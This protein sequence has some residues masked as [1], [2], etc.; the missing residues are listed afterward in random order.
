MRKA[1][2]TGA[3]CVMILALTA[4]DAFT[5]SSASP[6]A[7]L[8]PSVPAEP[9][10]ATADEVVAALG[11]AGVDCEVL[12]RRQGQAGSGSSLDCVFEDRG[13]TVETEISVFD[14]DVV[15]EGEIGRAVHSRRTP[16]NGQVLVAAGNWY[17]RVIPDDT[18]SHAQK[19]AR[20]LDAVVLPPLHPL[21]AIPDEPRYERVDALADALDE[22]VTCTRRK[23]TADGLL[24]A[25]KAPTAEQ[26]SDLTE[27]RDAALRLH[28]TTTARDDYLRLLLTDERRPRNIVTAGNWSIQ[29]CD[30]TTAR[31]AAEQ[32]HATI[33]TP[34]RP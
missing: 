14:T 24:C 6:K 30:A 32:L 4:C 5:R 21:P 17:L 20:A 9:R 7:A 23:Q 28:P 11:R 2:A 1:A 29:L 27:G 22:A 16:P 3:A 18:P 33:V 8:P 34:D 10:F 15:D 12:R 13:A 19:V 25:T 26:C 31:T